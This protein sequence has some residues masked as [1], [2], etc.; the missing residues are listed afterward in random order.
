M[1][2]SLQE[3]RDRLDEIIRKGRVDLY[4]PIQIAEVLYRARLD[5]GNVDVTDLAT[6]R[7]P[8]IHW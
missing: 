4:K 7:N 3:A 8:S 2:P 6:F 1:P 5:P